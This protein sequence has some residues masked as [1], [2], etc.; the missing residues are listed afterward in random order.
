MKHLKATLLLASAMGLVACQPAADSNTTQANA[1]SSEQTVVTDQNAY[2]L[3]V[4]I[5][6]VINN[7]HGKYANAN[8][9]LDKTQILAG[10]SDILNSKATLTLDE[11]NG[12]LREMELLAKQNLMEINAKKSEAN[13]AAG[14][15]FLAENGARPEVT[16][17]ES[18]LQYEVLVAGDGAMPTAA[19]TV[20]VHYRGTTIDGTEFDSSYSRNEPTSFP[21]NRVIK[22]WTEGLQLMNV[23]SK[24][25]FV[26][27]SEL[28]YGERQMGDDISPNSTLVF[29]VEL[30]DIT[31]AEKPAEEA[32]Q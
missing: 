26:I 23:G 7:A 16:T 27:P 22:G 2:A 14:Q 5:G 1:A 18:G 13:I 21:L 17:T 30:L 24:Y 4:S 25:R 9:Q 10:I 12:L 20:T 11:A 15:A 6:S 8:I 28:A 29:E 31:S 19:D 3:G 32:Q